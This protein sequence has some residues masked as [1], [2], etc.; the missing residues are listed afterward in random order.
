MARMVWFCLAWSRGLAVAGTLLLATVLNLPRH[1]VWE[2]S[3][4]WSIILPTCSLYS[5]GYGRMEI[6]LQDHNWLDFITKARQW[7]RSSNIQNTESHFALYQH[8]SF[9]DRSLFASYYC[10]AYHNVGRCIQGNLLVW[11]WCL[12]LCCLAICGGALIN[13]VKTHSSLS[14]W[15]SIDSTH[16]WIEAWTQKQCRTIAANRKAAPCVTP[17]AT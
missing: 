17:C 3:R 8:V 9:Q 12:Q 5:K 14:I 15:Q 4:R 1:L 11:H 16:L 10:E 13:C 2:P 6:Y 7:C